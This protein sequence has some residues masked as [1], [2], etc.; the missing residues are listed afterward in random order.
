MKLSSTFTKLVAIAGFGVGCTLIY[1]AGD[2][3]PGGQTLDATSLS[4]A[5]APDAIRDPCE[6]ALSAARPDAGDVGP[7]S[8]LTFAISHLA[9]VA[10]NSTTLGFDLDGICTCDTRPGSPRGGGSSCAPRKP[11]EVLC[12]GP[13]GRDNGAATLFSRVVPDR[14][15]AGVD[16]GF[17]LSASEGVESIVV[18]IEEYNGAGSDPSVLLALYDSPGLDAP[19]ACDGGTVLDAGVNSGGKPRPSWGGCDAWQIGE[20]SL[21]GGRPRTFTRVA[22]VADG[23]V[24]G[25]F[26]TMAIRIG[27]SELLL[28]DATFQATLVKPATGLL[29]LER[30]VLTGRAVGV[31]LLRTF[32]EQEIGGRALCRDALT[33]AVFRTAACNSF[34]LGSNQDAAAPCDSISFSA[35]IEAKLAQRGSVAKSADAA[36]GCLDAGD[37]ARCP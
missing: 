28:F 35:E 14:A 22:W 11:E 33:Y 23:V 26:G 4:D 1:D 31:D 10:G 19:K 2:F 32:G 36:T 7:R 18:Q 8:T 13:G 15:E 27:R 34:D 24:V 37:F 30:G 9:L 12:D 5:T 21:I 3:A 29:R 20:G 25:K 6:H 17:D 16:V